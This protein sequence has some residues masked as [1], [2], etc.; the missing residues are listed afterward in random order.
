MNTTDFWLAVESH[1]GLQ[2]M[3]RITHQMRFLYENVDFTG[4][5][6]L[7]IG[8]GTGLHSFYAASQGASDVTII[9]P[10][11]DGGHHEMISTF[12][13][14]RNAVDATN[15][16]LIQTTLQ[17]YVADKE[18]FQIIL[19]QDAINHFDEK[20]C[21]TLLTS[22]ESQTRYRKIFDEIA[23]LLVPGGVLI[24]SDC[25]S[26]NFFDAIGLINPVAKQI[27]WEK[28]QPPAVW[29]QLAQ[30]SGLKHVETRWSTPSRF[31]AIGRVLMGNPVAAW[32]FTSHFV[33]KLRKIQRA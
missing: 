11:A 5:S 2:T 16:K 22:M 33:I 13:S 17:N 1:Y 14:L 26:R 25:S 20:A 19:V 6:V 3:R 18:R 15:V 23:R 24:I 28:H 12:N 4:K 10:E 9:E 27:E 8:G 30:T 7:D 31:G 29:C 32:F 21:V